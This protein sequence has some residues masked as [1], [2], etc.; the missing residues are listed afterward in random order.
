MLSVVHTNGI[1][2]SPATS[3]GACA[4][5]SNRPQQTKR[6]KTTAKGVKA[7]GGNASRRTR[8]VP[9]SR[10]QQTAVHTYTRR[11]IT[12]VC[13]AVSRPLLPTPPHPT[14]PPYYIDTLPR[15]RGT[16][17]WLCRLR[18]LRF[19]A[20]PL[21]VSGTVWRRYTQQQYDYYSVRDEAYPTR[22]SI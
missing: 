22:T 15:S 1:R 8:D 7:R 5:V 14:P 18:R 2:A 13:T 10:L 11:S 20:L 6:W 9:G 21:D 16:R 19:F 17:D 3:T 4:P 12:L